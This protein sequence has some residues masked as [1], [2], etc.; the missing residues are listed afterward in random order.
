VPFRVAAEYM[1]YMVYIR[2]FTANVYNST[3]KTPDRRTYVCG[4]NWLGDPWTPLS[5]PFTRLERSRHMETE[6]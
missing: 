3:T 4:Y 6:L 1:Y 2:Q 5:Q